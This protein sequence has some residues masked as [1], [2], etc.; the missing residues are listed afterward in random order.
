MWYAASSLHYVPFNPDLGAREGECSA[1]RR[2]LWAH[3]KDVPFVLH[4]W[5]LI[6]PEA[7]RAGSGRERMT[8]E[9]PIP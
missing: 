4:P 6:V 7:M 2:V 5:E 8:G 1:K 9:V 3:E